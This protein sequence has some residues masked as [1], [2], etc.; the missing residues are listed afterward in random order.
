MTPSSQ[1]MLLTKQSEMGFRSATL[2]NIAGNDGNLNKRNIN[3]MTES[4]EPHRVKK[5][6]LGNL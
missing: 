1:K 5:I 6:R 4:Y 3:T 2:D